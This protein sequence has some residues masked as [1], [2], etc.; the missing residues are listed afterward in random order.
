[1][2]QLQAIDTAPRH[3]PSLNQTDERQSPDGS[4]ECP[5]QPLPRHPHESPRQIRRVAILFAGGPAPAANAV[6]STAAKIFLRNDIEVIGIMNGYSRLVDFPSGK[7]AW[8]ELGRDDIL[9]DQRVLCRTV[10]LAGHLTALLELIPAA[11]FLR[12]PS[13]LAEPERGVAMLATV[14]Q[15]LR[16]LKVDA[17]IS[18]GG[19]DTLKTANKFKMFQ[20]R[21]PEGPYAH[22]HCPLAQ[23]DRQ[24]LLGHRF[25]VRVFHGRRT[26]VRTEIR[27]LLADAE[28]TR[29]YFIAECMGRSAGWLAYGAAIAG[30]GSLALSVEDIPQGAEHGGDPDRSQDRGHQHPQDHG[31]RQGRRCDGEGHAGPRSRG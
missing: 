2:L 20:D 16:W 27:N 24:R 17:L 29:S 5:P 14:N 11:I 25:H 7:Q 22:S 30:E 28:A 26:N 1:M 9:L 23:D 13:H 10:Q 18:I 19:D 3:V 4:F 12:H 31:H 15:A 8:P 6:I 21:L